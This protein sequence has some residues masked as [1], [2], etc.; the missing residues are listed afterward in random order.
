MTLYE[1]KKLHEFK[2]VEV[3]YN[4]VHISQR[5]DDEHNILLYQIGGFYVEVFHHRELNIIKRISSFCG[6][7][8]LEPYLDQ[9]DIS[10]LT[11]SL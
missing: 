6:I 10:Q 4:S 3:I 8:Q 1:F 9:I 2:Q 7:R 5:W 11:R